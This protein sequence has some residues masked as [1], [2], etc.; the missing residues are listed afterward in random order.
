[1]VLLVSGQS[2]DSG[3]TF[4]VLPHENPKRANETLDWIEAQASVTG[5]LGEQSSA[6]L[7]KPESLKPWV[8]RW[9]PPASPLL[10]SHAMYLLGEATLRQRTVVPTEQ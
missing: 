9:G 2:Y 7:R 10:C 6:H 3:E 1:M 5:H 4:V 8:Q